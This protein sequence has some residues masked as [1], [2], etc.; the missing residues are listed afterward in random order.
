MLSANQLKERI[1]QL[2]STG[3][4][5]GM[6]VTCMSF[7]FGFG[8]P[9]D[10]DLVFDVRCLPNPFYVEEL[11]NKVGTDEPVRRFVMDH[12]EAAELAD[13][14]LGLLDYLIPLYIQ[15]GKSQLVISLGCTGGKHRSV[16]FAERIAAHCKEMNLPTN[17]I[18]RDIA[19]TK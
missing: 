10:S 13:R 4:E 1:R 19:R 9:V 15:E 2:F 8:V 18:H 14:L 3:A 7:G 6:V 12:P 11:R 5:P 17:I 16:V